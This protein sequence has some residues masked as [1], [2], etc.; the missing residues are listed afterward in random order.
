MSARVLQEIGDSPRINTSLAYS[1]PMRYRVERVPFALTQAMTHPS[2]VKPPI[3]LSLSF[4]AV[5][6][7]AALNPVYIDEVAYEYI[8][9]RFFKESGHNLFMVPECAGSFSLPVPFL[10]RIPRMILALGYAALPNLFALRAVGVLI[11]LTNARLLFL[12]LANSARPSMKDT[13]ALFTLSLMVGTLPFLSIYARPEGL[14]L[15]LALVPIYL[16]QRAVSYPSDSAPLSPRGLFAPVTVL[17]CALFAQAIHPLGILAAPIFLAALWLLIRDAGSSI[18]L[19]L[20][21]IVAGIL[22]AFSHSNTYSC[23]ELSEFSSFVSSYGG[24]ATLVGALDLILAL[25]GSLVELFSLILWL[26]P[27]RVGVYGMWPENAWPSPGAVLPAGIFTVWGWAALFYAMTAKCLQ[28]RGCSLWR[29]ISKGSFPAVL[30]LGIAATLCGTIVFQPH[31]V[32]YRLAFILP[33]WMVAIGLLLFSDTSS[34]HLES[35]ARTVRWTTLFSTISALV[36]VAA[37]LPVNLGSLATTAPP[38]Q[39]NS[40]SQFAPINQNDLAAALKAC[41]IAESVESRRV[42]VD[43]HT[44]WKM[45][46]TTEP[47]FATFISGQLS[48]LRAKKLEALGAGGCVLH[49]TVAQ[50]IF[51]PAPFRRFGDVCCLSRSDIQSLA[52]AQNN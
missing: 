8:L 25:P 36:S 42:I 5:Y 17:T 28:R 6:T 45:R 35:Y 1:L 44:Y 40:T 31:P 3:W 29:E 15:L 16:C 47:I 24:R 39:I 43:W 51:G 52:N 9:G 27:G 49:C 20:I 18:A 26:I 50:G 7:L 22:N 37:Y 21:V 34:Q 46:S 19:G 30:T 38:H 32:V 4:L 13:V 41:E 14:L 33:L 11:A 2:P 12:I 48:T 10:W 23:P